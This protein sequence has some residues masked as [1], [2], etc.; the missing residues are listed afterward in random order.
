MS[1][2][3]F[4]RLFRVSTF[5]ESHGEG[6][7][8]VIDGVPSKLHLSERD[9]QLE[10]NRRRPGQSRITTARS[11]ADRVRIISGIF[12]G[13]T[14]GTPLT[15]F[16]QNRSGKTEDFSE[17]EK[18]IVR[19]PD[20]K[21]AKAMI[22]RIEH[23]KA[24]G[25][26]AGGIVEVT[27]RGVSPGIGDPVFDRLDALLAHAVLSIGAVKGF[28]IGKGFAAARMKDSQYNDPYVMEGGRVQ[29]KTNNAGGILGGISTGED[30]V[31]RAAV[32]PPASIA[33]PQETVTRNG[34]R[35]TIEVHGRHDPC[36]VPRI[37]PVVEAMVGITIMDCYLIQEAI[38]N[39]S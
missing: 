35:K 9:I 7:G 29:T 39:T 3:C 4:G 38:K 2:N 12:Q 27:T 14:T 11:E 18:N 22:E 24:A 34:Q 17:I 28:E 23:A 1:G 33:K 19:R 32:R 15:L 31:L 20:K 5:G 10:L 37:V 26:S 30:I 13:C 21:L 36:I 8:V 25:E 16:I 6:V